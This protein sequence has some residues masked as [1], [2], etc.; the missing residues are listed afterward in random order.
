MTKDFQNKSH[1]IYTNNSIFIP[2]GKIVV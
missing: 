1:T 2:I